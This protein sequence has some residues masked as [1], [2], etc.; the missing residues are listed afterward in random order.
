MCQRLKRSPRWF[1]KW[2][3]RYTRPSPQ[4]QSALGQASGASAGR[5]EEPEGLYDLSHAPRTV[6]ES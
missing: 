5:L 3:R 2:W 6:I 1:H 4:R